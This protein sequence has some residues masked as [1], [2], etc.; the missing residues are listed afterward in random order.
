MEPFKALTVVIVAIMI[1]ATNSV[2]SQTVFEK[3]TDTIKIYDHSYKI[4]YL[5]DNVMDIE[6]DSVFVKNEI[7]GKLSPIFQI[8]IDDKTIIAC[9]NLISYS[10]VPKDCDYFYPL[11]EN[12]NVIL[13]KNKLHIG[14]VP[15][16]I[17]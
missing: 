5:D 13:F 17:R 6:M 7:F 10:G 12:N 9:G 14:K 1:L 15:S 2:M 3:E 4:V 8:F 16:S 11:D